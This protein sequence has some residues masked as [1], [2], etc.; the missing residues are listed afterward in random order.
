M[1]VYGMF[2][3]MDYSLNSISELLQ[4]KSGVNHGV[5][6][7]PTLTWHLFK[8]IQ[9]KIQMFIFNIIYIYLITITMWYY[10]LV[11]LDLLYYIYYIRGRN[12]PTL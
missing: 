3:L 11:L 4:L 5:I 12:I 8:Y 9:I 2:M 1:Y 7:T 6:E 10:Y